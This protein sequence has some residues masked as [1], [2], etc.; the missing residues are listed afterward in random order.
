V[1]ST[2]HTAVAFGINGGAMG[3]PFVDPPHH[4]VGKP[5]IFVIPEGGVALIY[6]AFGGIAK[7]TITS[8]RE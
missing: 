5:A 1:F 3:S 2:S 6:A 7:H 8:D 4:H